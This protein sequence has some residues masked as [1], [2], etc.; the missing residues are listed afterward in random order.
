MWKVLETR[1]AVRFDQRSLHPPRVRLERRL[2]RLLT[3][4]FVN[5]QKVYLVT[6]D[7]HKFKHLVLGDSYLAAT[8]AGNLKA[9]W[10]EQIFPALIAVEE[11]EIWL[12]FVDGDRIDF[13]NDDFVAQVA[14]FYS[15]VYNKN[16]Q[17]SATA[18]SRFNHEV[19]T[20][21]RFLNKL[22]VLR[23]NVYRE[24]DRVADAITPKNIWIEY[25]YTDPSPY[26][27]MIGPNG[28]LKAIDVES[29]RRDQLLGRGIAK[30]FRIWPEPY[31]DYLIDEMK[32][33]ATPDF[34]A[35][36]PFIEL[37]F[38]SD[39]V[40]RSIFHGKIHNVDPALF[41]QFRG[42]G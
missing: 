25:D 28:K 29:I 41:D 19:H 17:R 2:K 30:A 14:R 32:G 35:Y 33:Q 9:F 22:G 15:L 37:C 3:N 38:L 6:L 12:E 16:P 20:N 7:G 21:L 26:N 31:R 34:I 36:M 13:I 23:D 5:S 11:N 1:Q 42:M 40:K 39:W 24:L 10:A 18:V 8:I 4:Y 27:F